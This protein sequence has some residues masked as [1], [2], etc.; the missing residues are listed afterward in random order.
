[1]HN[2]FRAYRP[3][4]NR[5]FFNVEVAAAINTI[6]SLSETHAKI[7]FEEVFYISDEE[8]AAQQA[9]EEEIE[10]Q[11]EREKAT[12]IAEAE[13]SIQNLYNK[14]EIAYENNRRFNIKMIFIA[15]LFLT[16]LNVFLWH[17][18]F[19]EPFWGSSGSSDT[20][21]LYAVL[22]CLSVILVIWGTVPFKK[23]KNYISDLSVTWAED[24]WKDYNK[25]RREKTKSICVQVGLYYLGFSSL[26]ALGLYFEDGGFFISAFS[27]LLLTLYFALHI[28]PFVILSSLKIDIKT[29]RNDVWREQFGIPRRYNKKKY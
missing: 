9:K 26:V 1:M 24:F 5:E 28:A 20:I 6:R 3:N 12:E 27:G 21:F 15:P 14:M 22:I 2:A 7:K 8:I 17:V 10:R 4:K 16:V 19:N 11:K 23:Y 13:Q 29:Y 25:Y 18:I